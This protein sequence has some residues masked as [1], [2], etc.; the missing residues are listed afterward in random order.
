M[1]ALCTLLSPVLAFSHRECILDVVEGLDRSSG[2]VLQVGKRSSSLAPM[3]TVPV[4][5]AC[6]CLPFCM[7]RASHWH[8]H[9]STPQLWCGSSASCA[10][11]AMP[12]NLLSRTVYRTHA[13]YT[14]LSMTQ[15]H[16]RVVGCHCCPFPAA[17]R[18]LV[19]ARR[20]SCRWRCC[21]T[22]PP[23]SG[24]TPRRSWWGF[25]Q[26]FPNSRSCSSVCKHP[27]ARACAVF[28][29]VV[30]VCASLCVWR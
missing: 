29:V 2:L 5:A 3:C 10:C 7:R 14:C 20:R 11:A 21:G 4:D 8:E 13:P 19:P 15:M 16:I 17:R 22:G 30:V 26:P 27:C 25:L 28:V 1:R 12:C 9:C 6:K 23:T 18:R 24:R